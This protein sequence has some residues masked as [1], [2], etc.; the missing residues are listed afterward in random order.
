[1]VAEQTAKPWDFLTPPQTRP[2]SYR[3]TE[4]NRT[5]AC[6]LPAHV[7]LLITERLPLLGRGRHFYSEAEFVYCFC[8]PDSP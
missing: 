7:V 4:A 2:T 8:A 5:V 3:S 1:M 6:A